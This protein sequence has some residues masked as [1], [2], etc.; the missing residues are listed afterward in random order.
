MAKKLFYS[1][2]EVSEMFDVNASLIRFWETKFDI[3]R[4]QKNKKGNRL[5]SPADVENLKLIYHLVK[6]N[7]MTLAGAAKRLRQNREGVSRDLE[8]IEKLQRVRSL[9]LDVR[10]VLKA[11]DDVREVFVDPTPADWDDVPASEY[12]TKSGGEPADNRMSEESPPD[13]EAVGDRT[14]PDTDTAFRHEADN[15]K[16]DSGEGQGAAPVCEPRCAEV[17]EGLAE[18]VAVAT[19]NGCEAGP[20]APYFIQR[21]IPVPPQ[22]FPE[23]FS[24]TEGPGEDA[25]CSVVEQTLF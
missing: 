14:L 19:D 12:G 10:E 24:H 5:F 6:E 2:G 11:D 3:L 23:R 16:P 13:G 7:G 17:P 8:I 21:E 18:L 25:A 4:P 15:S 9:L 20:A 22:P 1:M